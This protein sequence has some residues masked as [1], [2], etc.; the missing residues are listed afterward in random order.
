MNQP[1]QVIRYA[2]NETAF[3]N[4]LN[5]LHDSGIAWRDIANM[6]LFKEN[7]IPFGTLCAI[8]NGA[9]VP[10]KWLEVLGLPRKEPA[11]VCLK[12]GVVHIR[13]TCPS[14]K[15]PKQKERHPRYYAWM[16]EQMTKKGDWK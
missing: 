10:K 16:F 14:T 3:R 8:A 6:K 4:A 2:P 15:A 1:D 13:K 7:N 5:R 9:E 11:P 12:C